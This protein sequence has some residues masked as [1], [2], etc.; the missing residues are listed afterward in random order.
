[1][2]AKQL[3]EALDEFR[4]L[5]DDPGK[6][7]PLTTWNK[8]VGAIFSAA[9]AHLAT[10]PKTKEAQVWRVEYAENTLSGWEPMVI[11]C[12]ALAD[13]GN[14]ARRLDGYVGY[15]CIRVTGPFKQTVPA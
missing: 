15:A 6:S 10:L 9:E 7:L 4:P 8:V 2:D 1:M 5:L 13:A 11:Q 3:E 12:D 14:E